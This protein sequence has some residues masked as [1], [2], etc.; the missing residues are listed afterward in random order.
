MAT[1]SNIIG[2]RCIIAG[3]GTG[4][5]LFPGIAVAGELKKF[6][7]DAEILF[8]VG[9]QRMESKILGTY[10]YPV[11]SIPVEGL[12][13]RGWK[14]GFAVLLR[15]P[16]AFLRSIVLI[17]RFSPRVVLGVGGYSSGPVCLAAKLLGLPVA[18]HEQNSI[19][20]L[21][22]RLLSRFADRIFVAFE[23]SRPYFSSSLVTLTGNPV[24]KDLFMDSD[25][26][27]EKRKGFTVLVLGGS[28][29][30][31]TVNRAFVEALEYVKEKGRFPRV[32][33]QTGEKDYSMVVE[34]YRK[35][36]IKGELLPF[37]QNMAWAYRSAD[38]VVSR[39]GA[40]TIFELACAGKASILIPYPYAANRHQEVNAQTLARTGGA[41]VIYA[42]EASR[43]RL[44]QAL[45]RYMDDPLRLE[46]MAR[47]AQKLSRPD[48]ARNIVK[49]LTEMAR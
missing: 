46:E 16:K 47:K 14:A 43:E 35:R 28:Q 41:E 40:T 1:S 34:D 20:G 15:L 8:V 12:K 48:A 5:H 45:I 49:H 2:F 27:M 38:L 24:R 31:R 7:R 6:L 4:G 19:P 13:G 30:A 44:G 9:R 29:G 10:G 18:I 23:E 21:T 32:I 36:G 3:G 17:K 42:H 26:K 37:I 39:A 22:N 25:K 11:R 33:H